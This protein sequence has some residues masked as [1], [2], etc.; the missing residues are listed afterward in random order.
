MCKKVIITYWK[1]SSKLFYYV[2]TYNLLKRKIGSHILSL[3]GIYEKLMINIYVD[4]S[5][6]YKYCVIPKWT[7]VL[8]EVATLY[9]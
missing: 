8:I 3:V 6:K 4:Y 9:L 7:T 2:G 5:S 1:L